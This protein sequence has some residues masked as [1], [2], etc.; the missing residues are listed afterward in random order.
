MDLKKRDGSEATVQRRA[1]EAKEK[2]PSITDFPFEMN[3]DCRFKALYLD[4]NQSDLAARDVADALQ[5]IQLLL[6][7]IKMHVD[8][9]TP[10]NVRRI[11]ELSQM[12]EFPQISRL[13]SINLCQIFAS[14][15][16]SR[17]MLMSVEWYVVLKAH[18]GC[19]T[20]IRCLL[21]ILEVEPRIMAYLS[22]EGLVEVLIEEGLRTPEWFILDEVLRVFAFLVES[23]CPR[24]QEILP[25]LTMQLIPMVFE[26]SDKQVPVLK[27]L[28]VSVK[29]CGELLRA[30]N[31]FQGI[32]RSI[33]EF[34]N[35]EKSYAAKVLFQACVSGFAEHL[36]QEQL[37]PAIRH[38]FASGVA[39]AEPNMYVTCMD[40]LSVLS[41]MSIELAH[42]ALTCGEFIVKFAST[43]LVGEKCAAVQFA[44]AIVRNIHDSQCMSFVVDNN[45]LQEM[46]SLVSV[47]GPEAIRDVL[48]TWSF[49]L[50]NINSI[51]SSIAGEITTVL[52]SDDATQ[53]LSDVSLDGSH[54]ELA[55]LAG[56]LLAKLA[57]N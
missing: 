15:E 10:D 34:A 47:A 12:A 8:F 43:G 9:F 7:P 21:E 25:E 42:L 45:L 3:V 18:I 44:C 14:I 1:G 50:A 22:S 49:L 2:L 35:V 53:C 56:E 54:D 33:Q 38:L 5:G 37:V 17:E 19:P 32:I 26:R 4:P 39:S 11:Y 13:A 52:H 29:Y 57:E 16:N 40:I 20:V 46:A 51:E 41:R 23:Q 48:D 24:A 6:F 31:L 28:P 30:Q 55:E 27:F 36:V